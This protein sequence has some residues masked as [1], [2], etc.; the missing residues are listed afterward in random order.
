MKFAINPI[1]MPHLPRHTA[2]YVVAD[3]V[4]NEETSVRKDVVV[5]QFCST[6]FR[7]KLARKFAVVELVNIYLID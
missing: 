3:R 1:D 2:L 5:F 7:G 4:E 6:S